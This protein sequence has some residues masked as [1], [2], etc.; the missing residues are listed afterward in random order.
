VPVL[1]CVQLARRQC[2]NVKHP[3]EFLHRPPAGR[4]QQCVYSKIVVCRSEQWVLCVSCARIAKKVLVCLSYSRQFKRPA[5][6]I[7][8]TSKWLALCIVST[9][10]PA[11]LASCSY[12]LRLSAA[13]TVS[14]THLLRLQG[15][16]TRLS[17]MANRDPPPA[18]AHS[19]C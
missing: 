8:Q 15:H 5:S 1:C 14:P 19:S 2:C 13:A 6:C 17:S 18:A 12:L 9:S 10:S 11:A 4:R 16:S 3:A 7:H